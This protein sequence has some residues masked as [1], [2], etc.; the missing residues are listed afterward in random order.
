MRASHDE[1]I[2]PLVWTSLGQARRSTAA[3]FAL[4]GLAGA[5]MKLIS[6]ED[7][8]ELVARLDQRI[9]ELAAMLREVG[10]QL[11]QINR[12]LKDAGIGRET[13]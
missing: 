6:A 11:E 1:A 10:K 8:H 5:A 7:V 2:L 13:T 12:N 4:S 9:D 3:L